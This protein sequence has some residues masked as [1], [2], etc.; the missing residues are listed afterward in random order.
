M[1]IQEQTIQN[2]TEEMNGADKWREKAQEYLN[3]WKRAQADLANY[4]KEEAERVENVVK[5][6]N[7]NIILKIL[8]LYDDLDRALSHASPEIE[9][10]HGPWLKGMQQVAKNFENLLKKHGVE[11]INTEGQSFDPDVHE[12]VNQDAESKEDGEKVLEEYRSGYAMHGKVIRPARVKI[13][14]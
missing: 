6:G 14:K 7:E 1:E 8:D 12:A 10:M 3:G 13:S 11:K 2:E 5:F 9:K 4:K